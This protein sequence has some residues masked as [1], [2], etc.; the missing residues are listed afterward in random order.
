MPPNGADGDY[1]RLQEHLDKDAPSV[2][3]LPG[4]TSTSACFPPRRST[5]TTTPTTSG[6]TSSR[7]SKCPRRE[8]G[9]YL[10]AGR[11]VAAA[12]E[13]GIPINHLTTILNHHDPVPL[14]YWRIG[15][16][17]GEQPR[18]RWSLMRDGVCVA[19]GWPDLGDLS[20]YE[21]DTPS[22]EKL[23]KLLGE[24][25]PGSPQQIGKAANQI[26]NFAKGIAPGETVLACDGSMVLGVGRVAG[27]YRYEPGSDFPHRRPVEW[28]SLDEWKMPEPEGL[29][30]TVHK[31]EK[32]PGQ[33]RR[34]REE[35][36]RWTVVVQP[37]LPPKTESKGG[38]PPHLGGIPGRIQSVLER[39]GQVILYGPPG[40]GKTYWAERTALDLARIPWRVSLSRSCLTARKARSWVEPSPSGSSACAASTRPTATRTSS[41]ATARNCTTGGCRFALRDGIFK[42]LCRDAETQ[43]GQHFYLIIDE[44]NRGDIPRIF[45]E[46]LTV[47]EKDKRGK[48]IILPLS[49]FGVPGAPERLPHRD[50]EHGRSVHRPPRHRPAAAVRLHR[51]DA[52]FVLAG[53]C[54][55]SPIF[56]LGPWLEALNR[57][58]CEHVGRDARNLQVGHSFLLEA[59]KPVKDAARFFRVVRDEIIP[60]L[61][62]YCYEDYDALHAILGSRLG[63]S[64]EPC[65]PPRPVRRVDA[66]GTHPGRSAPC[67]DILTS[68]QGGV[69]LG[70]EQGD[71]EPDDGEDDSEGGATS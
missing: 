63:R 67:P 59:G 1:K 7:C 15:T 6:S 53:G 38:K 17:N 19:I 27:D 55:R 47:I 48:S 9:R 2:S 18:N 14:A 22:K 29:Q 25:Y 23:I 41:R 56:P 8:T 65:H 49:R 70:T 13:L 64:A 40:T 21:N 54:H 20:G 43:P 45:G 16:S 12:H 28:L 39:K 5:I 51:V 52:G 32:V 46:L 24:R 71:V 11:Y 50:D 62:E 26:L 66:A 37:S 42:Q 33:P 57:R 58:I 10:C 60:L 61:E 3:N 44:I 30:T 36:A 34:G 4:V 69:T 31:I 35:I 68:T